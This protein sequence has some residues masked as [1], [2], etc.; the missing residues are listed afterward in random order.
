VSDLL[1][2]RPTDPVLTASIVEVAAFD[3]RLA[4]LLVDEWQGELADLRALLQETGKRFSTIDPTLANG[5]P[6]SDE[7]PPRQVLSLWASGAANK[8][9]ELDPCFHAAVASGLDTRELTTRVWRAQVRALLP[10]IEVE[11]RRLAEW[12]LR[13]RRNLN[14]YWANSDLSG[15][16]VGPLCKL[17]GETPALRSQDEQWKLI[18]W[19]RDAR[20]SLAH[21]DVV[22]AAQLREGRQRIAAARTTD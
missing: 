3:L 2:G 11:R 21:W 15:L 16:E 20:N 22:D 7:R 10:E 19:L 4:E 17:V 6:R 1:D 18:R 12:V 5:I 14:D 13:H 8:W 9:S